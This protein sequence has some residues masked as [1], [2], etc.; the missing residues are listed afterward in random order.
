M[1]EI[2]SANPQ[3]G[4]SG[5][6]EGQSSMSKRTSLAHWDCQHRSGPSC[7]GGSGATVAVVG[8]IENRLTRFFFGF[9]SAG[10]TSLSPFRESA[11]IS[12]TA[13]PDTG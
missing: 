13:V 9:F 4:H 6:G 3:P 11:I 1:S 10:D 8:L 2:V 7:S 12:W 5:T